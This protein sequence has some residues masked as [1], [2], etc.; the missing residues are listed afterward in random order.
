[1]QSTQKH[2]AG[3]DQQDHTEE[4]NSAGAR[5]PRLKPGERRV[6][7]LQ[8]LA[9]MLET[10]KSEK[11]TTAAL[12]ARL[13]VSE[14]ALYR[15]FA[16]KAQMFEALIEF[17]EETFFGLVNQI[18]EKE[19]NGVLQARAI[20]LM[21]LNFSAKNPGMTRVLTGEALVGEHERL[22]ERVAQMLER[23]EASL[24]QCLRLGLMEFNQKSADAPV[25]LPADYDPAVRASLI[26]SYVLGRWH[27]YTKSGFARMPGEHADAQLRLILQ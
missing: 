25:P 2:D 4:L 3:V 26:I 19:P 27:R 10:P 21:L 7:I 18:T 6:H 24:K 22:A 20:G 13:G 9:A 23:I 16:S 14:A 15:H 5:A 8:T 11:I 1:M 17:I 12:A